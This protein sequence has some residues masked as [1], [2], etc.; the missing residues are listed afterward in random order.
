M[1]RERSAAKAAEGFK[2]GGVSVGEEGK[3]TPLKVCVCVRV[4]GGG[5]GGEEGGVLRR[6]VCGRRALGIGWP[7]VPR[8]RHLS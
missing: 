2:L 5:G 7:P 8:V 3:S 4:G 6:A 1:R